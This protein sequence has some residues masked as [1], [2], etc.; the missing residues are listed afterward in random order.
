MHFRFFDD[1]M[2]SAP[3]RLQNFGSKKEGNIQKKNYSSI[4]LK[5]VWKIY[6]KFAQ[7]SKNFQKIV[8]NFW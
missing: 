3:D 8:L 7:K 2:G 5:Y 6:I 1:L 4:Y